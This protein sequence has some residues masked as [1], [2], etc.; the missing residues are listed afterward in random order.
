MSGENILYIEN[1]TDNNYIFEYYTDKQ[2][3]MNLLIGDNRIIKTKKTELNCKLSSVNNTIKDFSFFA[4]IPGNYFLIKS[5]NSTFDILF[6][7]R[8][9]NKINLKPNLA[10]S[11]SQDS[12]KST[13]AEKLAMNELNK[14]S[15][16]FIS[17]FK[18][19]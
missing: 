7:I 9:G 13:N 18:K 6:D 11:L 15:K 14:S 16:N 10:I 2:N 19:I 3:F 1:K 5:P 17:L 4:E 12:H 8:N